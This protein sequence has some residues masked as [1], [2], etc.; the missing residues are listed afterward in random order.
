MK[1]SIFTPTYNRAE[2]LVRCFISIN[3]Q[4][5][6]LLD[7]T[8]WIVINDG[9]TDSTCELIHG[10]MRNSN[11]LIRYISQ[12]NAGKQAAWN[13]AVNHAR[14]EFFLGLD[15]D[16][17]LEENALLTIFDDLNKLRRKKK[18]IAIRYLAEK[19][20][21][22]GA[23]KVGSSL[24]KDLIEGSWFDEF[25]NPNINGE[26]IDL[27][28]TAVLKSYFFPVEKN[29]KYIPEYWF[30]C[31]VSHDGFLFCYSPKV[32]RIIHD[33]AKVNRLSHDNF[34]KNALGH[35]IAKGKMLSTI[36]FIC[37]IKNPK[38]YIK[39]IV[40]YTQAS[41]ITKN[42]IDSSLPV[43][44]K[45]LCLLLSIFFTVGGRFE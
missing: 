23:L 24:S 2:E 37:F 13:N 29:I 7:Q 34:N 21:S 40:R 27:F 9:S 12:E 41:K 15:S 17:E 35:Y 32:V 20:D 10:L 22:E 33:T 30:F 16:D 44:H 28:K 1:L 8:E 26:R 4:P 36:P 6:N 11:V 18:N 39:T 38:E 42:K 45:C 25:S 19:K 43:F 3:K 31:S 14:G 5:L